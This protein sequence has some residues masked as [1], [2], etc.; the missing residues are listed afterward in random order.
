M[1]QFCS[2]W[3]RAGTVTKSTAWQILSMRQLRLSLC[4]LG[5][6]LS[7]V[8]ASFS[9]SY[10]WR[11]NL[12]NPHPVQSPRLKWDHS[13]KAFSTLPGTGQV[14]KKSQLVIGSGFFTYIFTINL[15][16]KVCKIE[17][18]KKSPPINNYYYH[19]CVFLPVFSQCIYFSPDII[20]F[21]RASHVVLFYVALY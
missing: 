12:K 20:F 21:L 11:D 2:K 8:S 13:C 15:Y 5:K 4:D 3:N 7:P 14:L 17:K 6:V 19:D 1:P 16:C 9:S 10:S 18:R